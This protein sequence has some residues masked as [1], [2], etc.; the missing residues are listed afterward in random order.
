MNEAVESVEAESPDAEQPAEAAKPK[1]KAKAEKPHYHVDEFKAG[2]QD[3]FTAAFNKAQDELQD[4]EE[5]DQAAE[6]PAPKPEKA[7]PKKEVKAEPEKEAE[8]KPKEEPEAKDSQAEANQ[9]EKP[10]PEPEKKATGPLEPKK[11]WSNRRR[12]A[13]KFQPRHV[14]EAWLKEPPQPDQRW[15]EE[16]K[17]EFA[18]IP[19]Q[20]QE[21]ILL[22]EQERERGYSEK[23]ESLAEERK[24]VE[25]IKKS[26][27][28]QLRSAMEQRGLNEAD[29]FQKL[30]Q[31]QVFALANPKA[32]IAKFMADAR[33][34]PSDVFQLDTN[35]QHMPPQPYNQAAHDIKAHPD[36]QAMQAEL[37]E[38]KAERQKALE[39]EDERLSADIQGVL[40][41]TDG[42]GNSLYPFIRVL[43]AP[44]AE[45][46]ESDPERF[47]ALGTKDRVSVAYFQALEDFP[48]LQAIHMAAPAI[49][50][51]KVDE[52][53]P[54]PIPAEPDGERE[55]I[56]KLEKAVTPKSQTPQTAPASNKSGDPFEKAYQSALKKVK[57]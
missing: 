17:A 36:F 11:W 21:L 24:L 45:I 25:K 28:P 39:G 33:L 1:G 50:E 55:R 56:A 42:E 27:P 29:V 41:E 5:P 34:N 22:R 10:K 38:L 54:D 8:P 31:Q 57:R 13:F 48:E 30:A 51:V 7:Q 14:Q 35:G 2:K 6:E 12:E 9:E 37:Q 23:F 43:A 47:N 16:Q 52:P 4:D 15:T 32:Y 46:I 26:V 53:K 40:S 44:M 49:E 20:G 3:P 18:K 19:V